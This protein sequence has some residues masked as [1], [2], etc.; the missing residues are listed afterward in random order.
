M[1]CEL[2]LKASLSSIL[3]K[4]RVF[5]KKRK[6]PFKFVCSLLQIIIKKSQEKKTNTPPKKKKTKNI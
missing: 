5:K 3:V 4:K 1:H 6:Q 2:F